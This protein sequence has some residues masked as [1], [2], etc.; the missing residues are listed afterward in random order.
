MNKEEIIEQLKKNHSAF[1]GY[2][3]GL[4]PD[5]FNFSL[6]HEKWTAGQ[7]AGHIYLSIKPLNKIL[8]YPKWL[9]KRLLKKANRPSKTFEGLI[10]KYH[11]KLST[12]RKAPARFVMPAVGLAERKDLLEKVERSVLKLCRILKNYSEQEMD[13]VVLPHPL[14]GYITLREMMYFTIYHVE[15]HHKIAVRNLEGRMAVNS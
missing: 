6:N 14:L 12:G 5:E 9:T 2:V 1:T 3:S 15:H 7:Q 10:S 13:S 8:S 4:G 11:E